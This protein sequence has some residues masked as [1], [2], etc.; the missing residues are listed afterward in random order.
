MEKS[1]Q[2]VT[3]VR[4]KFECISKTNEGET[5]RALFRVVTDGSKENDKFFKFTPG[6][7]LNLFVVSNE[8]AES[9]IE[10]KFYYVDISPAG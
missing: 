6:G 2:A 7:E 1:A 3:R 8:T 9:F 4:A 10:G 5:N